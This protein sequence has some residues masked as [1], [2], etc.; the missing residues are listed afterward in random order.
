MTHYEVSGRYVALYFDGMP[1]DKTREILKACKW[2]WYSKNKCWSNFRTEQNITMA[3]SICE[4]SAKKAEAD[5]PLLHMSRNVFS[6]DTLIVRSNTLF[7][8]QK[9]HLID[10][11]GEVEILDKSGRY[12]L[13]LFPIVYCA[14]CDMY[15]LLEG[16]YK[17]LREKGVLMCQVMDYKTYKKYGAYSPT[18]AYWKEESPLKIRGYSVSNEAGLSIIQRRE[19]LEDIVKCGTLSK[20]RVL[21]YLDFFIKLNHTHTEAVERWQDDREHICNYKIE[22]YKRKQFGKMICIL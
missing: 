17:K 15:F 5:N 8:D 6:Q 10:M 20:Q 18:V 13:C 1:D 7:C 16:T 19:I 21:E 11:A 4:M 9:H 12:F 22:R 14:E 2:R 3:K